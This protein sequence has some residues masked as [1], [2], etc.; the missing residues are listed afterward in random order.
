MAI[1]I[2]SLVVRGQFGKPSDDPVR[3]VREVECRVEILHRKLLEEVDDRL[4]GAERRK[5]ER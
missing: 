5:K 2:G 1:E 3:A 4:A